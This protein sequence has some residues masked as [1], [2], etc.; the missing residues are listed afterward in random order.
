MGI[1]IIITMIHATSIT[2]RS[3]IITCIDGVYLL[4]LE[5]LLCASPASVQ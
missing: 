3:I 2:P 1:V 4:S 5:V